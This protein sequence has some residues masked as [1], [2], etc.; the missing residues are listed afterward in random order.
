VEQFLVPVRLIWSVDA[1]SG[2]GSG[3]KE[4]GW[5]V[6]PDTTV[7]ALQRLLVR[8]NTLELLQ[9]KQIVREEKGM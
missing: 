2:V 1:G 8:I 6:E 5:C 4:I 3:C 9:I 7:I